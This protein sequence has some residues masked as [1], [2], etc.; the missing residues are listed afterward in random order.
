[1]N[2]NTH[3]CKLHG[4]S[5]GRAGSGTTIEDR[6]LNLQTPTPTFHRSSDTISVPLMWCC[7]YTY[8]VSNYDTHTHTHTH[9]PYRIPAEEEAAE[10]EDELTKEGTGVQ[11]N[12]SKQVLLAANAVSSPPSRWL[13]SAKLPPKSSSL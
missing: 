9:P 2:C 1:M 8:F 11:Q 3:V 7:M 10:E 4:A 13:I 6:Q 5:H 12:L